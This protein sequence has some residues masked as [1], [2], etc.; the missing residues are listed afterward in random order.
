MPIATAEFDS[1]PAEVTGLDF[2][3]EELGSSIPTALAA[4]G[5]VPAELTEPGLML[6]MLGSSIPTALAE[7]DLDLMLEISLEASGLSLTLFPDKA[8]Q[9]F[10]ATS[11]VMSIRLLLT[12]NSNSFCDM[13]SPGVATAYSLSFFLPG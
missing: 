3:L 9:L 8:S 7:L 6:E 5:L 13:Q 4:L 12:Q 1:L 2:I 10:R 11:G